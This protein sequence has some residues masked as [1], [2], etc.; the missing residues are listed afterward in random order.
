M[1]CLLLLLVAPCVADLADYGRVP[2]GSNP[3]LYDPLVD[4]IIQLD[5]VSFDE[6]V[7]ASDAAFTIEFYADWCGHCRAFAPFYKAFA[8]DVRRW[9]PVVK[10]AA[11]NCAD[12][13]NDD[14]CRANE[15][16][17]FPFMKVCVE[18]ENDHR[19]AI[20]YRKIV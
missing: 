15:V 19:D 7:L 20:V 5:N 4:P 1:L 12:P 6:T 2:H 13:F 17:Y 10:V 9:S 3:V 14:I 16:N 11:I 18:C 8:D